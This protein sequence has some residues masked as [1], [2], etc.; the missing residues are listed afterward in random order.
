M[1]VWRGELKHV[2]GWEECFR[3]DG[4]GINVLP[5]MVKDS[6]VSPFLPLSV[7]AVFIKAVCW[8][9]LPP[10]PFLVVGLDPLA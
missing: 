8:V 1:N 5:L 4:L 3:R 9:V 10:F 6:G 7:V 2:V